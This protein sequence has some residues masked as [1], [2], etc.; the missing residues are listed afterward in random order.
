MIQLAF[1]SS[2]EDT[3]FLKLIL[4][5]VV[6]Q[7]NQL[8][9]D[10]VHCPMIGPYLITVKPETAVT[11]FTVDMR[12]LGTFLQLQQQQLHG[13]KCNR[14]CSTLMIIV[15]ISKKWPMTW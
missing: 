10:N 14:T 13:S 6:R 8:K 4:S 7:Q 2:S 15:G 5:L 12:M 11:G 9:T 1:M 3:G